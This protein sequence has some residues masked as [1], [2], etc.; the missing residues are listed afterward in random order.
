MYWP[1][2]KKTAAKLIRAKKVEAQNKSSQPVSF[3]SQQEEIPDDL[4]LVV[5]MLTK[6]LKEMSAFQRLSQIKSQ[7]LRDFINLVL[8]R[9]SST[10]DSTVNQKDVDNVHLSLNKIRGLV[11]A[12]IH[13]IMSEWFGADAGEPGKAEEELET[14]KGKCVVI[15]L[16]QCPE[17]L[18]GSA[19]FSHLTPIWKL[20]Q[21]WHSVP[22]LMD[23]LSS[24]LTGNAIQRSAVLLCLSELCDSFINDRDK[25][26]SALKFTPA[27]RNHNWN[28]TI[29]NI[30]QHPDRRTWT[31]VSK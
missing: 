17:L 11:L 30:L 16:C 20:V 21:Q 10:G 3:D 13:R 15:A 6:L 5:S 1:E 18:E 19:Q 23:M 7:S 25:R 26:S 12:E 4:I 27:V 28:R 24:K 9:A 14:A 22:Y 8:K 31:L 2:C 29:R